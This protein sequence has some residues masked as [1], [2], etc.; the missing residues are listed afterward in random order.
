MA[1]IGSIR[2]HGVALMIIIGIALLA[3]I[4][5][6]LSQVTRTFSN[7]NVMA[8]IDGKSV[9]QE[10]RTLYDQTTSLFRLLQNKSSF[11]ENETAQI[12]Q[13]TWASLIQEKI[14]DK[15]LAA[16]GL[17]YSSDMVEELK[18]EMLASLNTQQP[19]QYMMQFAQ[20]L[21]NQIGPEQ[22][23]A[24]L[25]NI[26]E[27]GKDERGKDLY[28]AYLAIVRYAALGE[29]FNRYNALAQNTLY[30]SDPLAKQLGE[31]NKN[32]M[33]TMMVVSPEA[34]AFKDITASVSDKEIKDFYNTHKNELFVVTEQN[35]DID[36]AIFPINPSAADLK[37]IEDSVRADYA[38]F[39]TSDMAA[40]CTEMNRNLDSTYYKEE[41]IVL[42]GLDSILFKATAVGS[43]IEPFEYENSRWYYGKVFGAAERPD[44]IH[45]ALIELPYKNSQNQNETRT[46]KEAA[47]LAD[48]LKAVITSNQNSIFNLQ[49]D[50]IAGERT[51]STLWLPERG[52]IVELYNGLIGTPNGGVYVY[53]AQGGYLVLQVLERTAPVSKRQFVLFD[54]P[55]NPSD[56]TISQIKAQATE[57]A[58]SINNAEELISKA[59]AKG[60]QTVRG[61]GVPSMSASIGQLQSCRDIVS[62]AFSDDVKKDD[63]S[64]VINVDKMF[65]A[66]AAVNN[67]RKTGTQKFEDVKADIEAMMTSEKKAEAI[68]EKVNK[69]LASSNM[70]TL[71]TT[72]GAQLRDSVRLVFAGDMYQNS[73][74]D[75]KALGTIF[76]LPTN[77]P[78]AVSGKNMV[79]VVDV[80]QVEKA[81]PTNEL[82]L[83]KNFLQNLLVG[84]ERN[85]S[86]ILNYLTKEAKV[87]DNRNRFY[88]N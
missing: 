27:Y 81:T 26:E 13:T 46:R 4:L 85:E 83:E 1:A 40:F 3:F 59:A 8:K 10:Y 23:M 53:K 78:T 7:K 18:S 58:A 17:S 41:D 31:N 24:V 5:G 21:A 72:Y 64:D 50:Y 54:Y 35:R 12:H 25:S 28:N 57:F 51:D 87:M 73:G 47:A 30:F 45:V 43:F 65:F 67:V 48:S 71:A 63:I 6:D 2:K 34:P 22:T 9:D 32:A 11:D 15:Q 39:S 79:Y 55:I 76:S 69:D 29:K 70:E 16:L 74:V 38:K 62:W 49:R 66:V 44:S 77:K 86:T 68:A 19:N 52:T 80:K 88:Q 14:L 75:G 56:A 36:V 37:A 82:Y 84:R 61:T 33:V 60:I 20:A 42:E